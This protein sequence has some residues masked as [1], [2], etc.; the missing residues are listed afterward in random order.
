[1]YIHY[2]KLD[3]TSFIH[4]LYIT[5]QEN[6]STMFSGETYQKFSYDKL[7]ITILNFAGE[8]NIQVF[9]ITVVQFPLCQIDIITIMKYCTNVKKCHL[10]TI[11]SCM[12]AMVIQRYTFDSDPIKEATGCHVI[13]NVIS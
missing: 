10:L 7:G 6:I 3:P 11:L 4:T 12:Q 2:D 1:M 5:G 13:T 9:W 8:L